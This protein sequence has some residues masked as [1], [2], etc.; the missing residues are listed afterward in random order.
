MLH[1]TGF[2]SL[3]LAYL[4]QSLPRAHAIGHCREVTYLFGSNPQIPGDL[5]NVPIG[6]HGDF[7]A[8]NGSDLS[9]TADAL[10][11]HLTAPPVSELQGKVR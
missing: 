10:E 9:E 8:F 2:L 11:F 5:G 1:A 7:L 4:S 6:D 3:V